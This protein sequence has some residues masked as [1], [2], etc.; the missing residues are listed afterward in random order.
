MTVIAVC[1]APRPSPMAMAKN[2]YANSSGSLIA[3]RNL[4]I[5]KAPTSPKDNAKDDFTIVIINIVVIL[6]NKKFRPNCFLLDNEL[7]YFT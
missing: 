6:N 2:R 4:I 3:A 5:D 7:P 1:S